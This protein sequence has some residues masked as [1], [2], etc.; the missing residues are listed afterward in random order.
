MRIRLL[1]PI[2]FDAK[3]NEN[4]APTYN[5]NF[6]D[7]S[8]LL[9]FPFLSSGGVAAGT[10]AT[11]SK[12]VREEIKW[13]EL[14]AHFR[15]VQVKHER[16]RR[17]GGLGI[18]VNGGMAGEQG[19][20]MAS[21]SINGDLSGLS[22]TS[23]T[24]FGGS[25]GGDRERTGPT[26]RP[27]SSLGGGASRPSTRRRTS[28]TGAAVLSPLNP[29]SRLAGAASNG[30]VSGATG[31]GAFKSNIGGGPRPLSPVGGLEIKRRGTVGGRTK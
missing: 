13:L 11:R 28:A 2:S 6:A 25:K 18:G 4:Q 17:M 21:Y 8:L 9:A 16:S 26:D 23:G 31:G 1:L 3:P 27:P 24:T 19:S 14:L 15:A 29:K 10:L 5:D 22:N 20:T 12:I 7:A 30:V